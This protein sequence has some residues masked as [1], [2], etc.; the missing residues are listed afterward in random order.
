MT[1]VRIACA[2]PHLGTTA[3]GSIASGH[4]FVVL[5]DD[6]GHRA[7]GLW[8][9]TRQGRALWRLLDRT[10]SDTGPSRAPHALQGKDCRSGS[11][12]PRTWPSGCLGPPAVP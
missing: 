9:R 6:A 11:S 10:A 4:I 8:P 5:A 12:P 3:D 1:A 2:Q 7:M